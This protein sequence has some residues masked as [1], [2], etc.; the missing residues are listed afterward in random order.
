LVARYLPAELQR[1]VEQQADHVGTAVFVALGEHKRLREMWCAARFARGYE[2][3]FG[4]CHIDVDLV[5]EQRE[6]DFH[7]VLPGGAPLP[8]QV[9][10]VLD[11]GRRRAEEYSSDGAKRSDAQS[12]KLLVRGAS[13]PERRLRDE[14]EKKVAKHY[15]DS[16]ELH[17]LA[18]LNLNAG[19]LPWASMAAAAEFA[20]PS[21]ASIWIVTDG[22]MAC[23]HG[24]DR[25]AGKIG[26]KLIDSSA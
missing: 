17:L 23:L 8:F 6:Y 1:I 18:Y 21:F 4:T 13:Y 26:W 3:S 24:G 11:A 25:W 22:L 10:E 7:L 14:L 2:R 16:Q 19:S 20:A 15:A 9:F 12:D 5:D